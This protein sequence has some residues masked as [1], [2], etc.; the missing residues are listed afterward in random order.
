M[1]SFYVQVQNALIAT[2]PG[3]VRRAIPFAIS[4]SG[5]EGV[6][7]SAALETPEYAPGDASSDV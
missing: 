7:T 4:S 1:T 3:T 6:A 2:H 5:T